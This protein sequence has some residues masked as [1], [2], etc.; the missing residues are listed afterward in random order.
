MGYYYKPHYFESWQ[1]ENITKGAAHKRA[2]AGVLPYEV[3]VAHNHKYR[4]GG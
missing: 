1:F 3:N 2:R 4:G